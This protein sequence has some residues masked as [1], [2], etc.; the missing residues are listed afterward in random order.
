MKNLTTVFITMFV[1]A[2]I[3]AAVAVVKFGMINVSYH[4]DHYVTT[5]NGVVVSTED[6]NVTDSVDF[7]VE[8]KKSFNIFSR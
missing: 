3:I 2:V 4:T 1:T 6:R 7:N 5:C 8:V